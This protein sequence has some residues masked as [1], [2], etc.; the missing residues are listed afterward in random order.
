MKINDPQKFL[1]YRL[2]LAPKAIFSRV[3]VAWLLTPYFFL[4]QKE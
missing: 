1:D 4:S 2:R 3:K